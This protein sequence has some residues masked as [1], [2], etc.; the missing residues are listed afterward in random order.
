MTLHPIPSDFFYFWG[1]FCYLFYQC[2]CMVSTE[3][4][5]CK[6]L[7]TQVA[8]IKHLFFILF[9]CIFFWRARVCPHLL[10]LCRPFMIFEGCLV[11]TQ[12]AAVASWRATDLA[13]HPSLI[14]HLYFTWCDGNHQWP[15]IAELFRRAEC[16]EFVLIWKYKITPSFRNNRDLSCADV[17]HEH[18]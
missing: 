3:M 4:L 11:W 15:A 2:A 17:E 16:N 14:K 13:T 6:L 1:K 18:F 10:R 5:D 12:S 8:G 7:Q 9:F